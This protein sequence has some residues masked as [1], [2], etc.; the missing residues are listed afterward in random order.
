MLQDCYWRKRSVIE[1]LLRVQDVL[2]NDS[3]TNNVLFLGVHNSS[4]ET[5][6]EHENKCKTCGLSQWREPVVYENS[7]KYSQEK[8][9]L[10]SSV[11]VIL[12]QKNRSLVNRSNWR[13]DRYQLTRAYQK[14]W[15]SFAELWHRMKNLRTP[16]TDF[17]TTN[18]SW[19]TRAIMDGSSYNVVESE[20]QN[21]II[22]LFTPP[23]PKRLGKF[24]TSYMRVILTLIFFC[25]TFE[26]Y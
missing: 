17:T 20:Y 26:A 18:C 14:G 19:M 6:D 1:R 11:S 2:E 3:R 25:L 23:T 4:E 7:R 12:K 5:W 8:S 22:S 13:T 21:T 10:S 24:L 15:L 9:V 16:S